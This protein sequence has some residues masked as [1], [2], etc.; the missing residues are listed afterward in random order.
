[1]SSGVVNCHDEVQLEQP[2]KSNGEVQP[3]I[4]RKDNEDSGFASGSRL[5]DELIQESDA[6]SVL[7]LSSSESFSP[8]AVMNIDTRGG[9]STFGR[10][11]QF[12][13]NRPMTLRSRSD[14]HVSGRYVRPMTPAKVKKGSKRVADVCV[15]LFL[16]DLNVGL[17][18]Y[19]GGK[20]GRGSN[21]QA[22]VALASTCLVSSHAA[23]TKTFKAKR[24][25]FRTPAKS[26]RFIIYLYPSVAVDSITDDMVKFLLA[27]EFPVKFWSSFL[28]RVLSCNIVEVQ[29]L[30][31]SLDGSS[32][33]RSEFITPKKKL[34]VDGGIAN[35]AF[36]F[37]DDMFKSSDSS[38]ATFESM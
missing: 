11:D 10:I 6:S 3:F 32:T 7:L 19:C 30:I 36:T 1:M 26:D 28:P 29:E 33:R 23:K 34:K 37:P 25:Y 18:H 21:M 20:V 27:L 12:S 5:F 16:A 24:V 38:Q 35:L 8:S 2:G 15:R 4:R 22:C 9:I 13:D 14:I 17:D 31:A